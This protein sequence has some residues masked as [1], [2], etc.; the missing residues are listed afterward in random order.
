MQNAYKQTALAFPRFPSH[1]CGPASRVNDDAGPG[2]S[3]QWVSEGIGVFASRI[4]F[5]KD[6]QTNVWLIL[7]AYFYTCR[8]MSQSCHL[9]RSAMIGLSVREG[10]ERPPCS[11]PWLQTHQ[12]FEDCAETVISTARYLTDTFQAFHLG[13]ACLDLVSLA[14]VLK[15]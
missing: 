10:G 1:S 14:V 7:L 13:S 12:V 4:Q 15:P 11:V 9:P 5:R 8:S 6:C 2:P 3:S